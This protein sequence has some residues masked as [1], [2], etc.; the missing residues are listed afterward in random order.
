MRRR[1]H[2]PI[3][4]QGRW[5]QAG[6]DGPLR[7]LRGPDKQPGARGVPASC[8]QPLA[9]LAS[10]TQPARRPDL[11]PYS[12]ARK[13]L[14]SQTTHPTSLAEHAVCRHTPEVGAGCPNWARPDLCGGRPAMAVPTANPADRIVAGAFNDFQFHDLVLQQTKRPFRV[15]RRRFGAGERDQPGLFLTIEDPRDRWPLTL[16][17]LDTASKPS[18]TSRCRVL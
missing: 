17:A 16:L 5:L 6:R 8:R 14:A 12:A 11:G 1:R 2:Q 7:L 3:P 18:S 15:S 4:E 13:R 9:A 10:A